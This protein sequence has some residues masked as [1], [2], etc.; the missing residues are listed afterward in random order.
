[1]KSNKKSDLDN[2][3]GN[4]ALLEENEGAI[5]RK[6]IEEAAEIRHSPAVPSWNNGSREHK[7]MMCTMP[8]CG[9]Q[10]GLMTLRQHIRKE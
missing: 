3:P 2:V 8:Q 10:A 1:V 9:K 5:A 7:V 6:R 4:W